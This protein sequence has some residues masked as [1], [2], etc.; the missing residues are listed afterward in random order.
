MSGRIGVI[1]GSEIAVVRC[2]NRIFLS[3]L[4]VFAIPLANAG[5][6]SISENDSTELSQSLQPLKKR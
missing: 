4:D 5:A 1:A 6:T 2:D 3:L